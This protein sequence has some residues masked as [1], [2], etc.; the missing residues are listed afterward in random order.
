MKA[1]SEFLAG[2]ALINQQVEFR[3]W[4]LGFGG[5]GLRAQG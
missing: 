4:S 1:Y 5:S 2:M 3:V